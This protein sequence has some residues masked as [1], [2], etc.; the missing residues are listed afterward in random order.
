M[1]S[2][3]YQVLNVVS[4]LACLGLNVSVLRFIGEHKSEGSAILKSFYLSALKFVIPTG[5][6]I[7]AFVF[8][9]S[10]YIQE[11][12]ESN[13]LKAWGI[14][15]LAI[16][17]P[18]N[19][20]LVLT[21]EFIRGLKLIRQSE[22]IRSIL[23]PLFM[24]ILVLFS[25]I[26]DFNKDDI[27]WMLLIACATALIIALILLFRYFKHTESAQ[28]PI[29]YTEMINT[30]LPLMITYLFS[31]L[32]PSLP[33]FFLGSY[34]SSATVGV[35]SIG[36]RL[37]AGVAI[38]L[39]IVNTIS[40]PKFA[41]LYWGKKHEEL[42]S[43]IIKT[44][45]LLFWMSFLISLALIIFGPFVLG[46]FGDEFN[47]ST[48]YWV[49]IVLVIGQLINVSAGSVGVYLSM[50]GRQ[51]VLRNVVAVIASIALINYWLF[52][53]KYGIKAVAIISSLSLILMNVILV[54]YTYVKLKLITFYI[55]GI[56]WLIKRK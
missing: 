35:F 53:E 42:E 55:P 22:M 7:A 48:G 46:L 41:E 56:E 29:K 23:R 36:F 31:A 39:T 11:I 9:S 21:T 47:T 51:K 19:A 32:L 18:I 28:L 2:L 37:A 52:T 17:I 50:T 8:L 12:F 27:V 16:T 44:S 40:A 49:L 15:I 5:L 43:L 3:I 24:L 30:S 10:N 1:Y 45:K 33:I 26:Y 38:L 14:K 4:I 34:Y 20:V 54:L 13:S 6:I 25:L